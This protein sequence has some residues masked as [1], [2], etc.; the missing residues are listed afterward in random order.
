ME[1]LRIAFDI[2]ALDR[3]GAE[4]QTLEVA[5]GLSQAGHDV[6][7][8]VNKRADNFAEY[9]DQ[10]GIVELG[11]SSRWDA[12]VVADIRRALRAYDA[13]VCVCVLFNATLWGRLAAAWV[14]CPVVVAEHSTKA[15]TPIPE[16]SANVLLG[17]ATRA[18]IACADSQVG[19]LVRGGH[20]R[21]KIRVVRNG[22]NVGRF[23]PDREEAARL[24]ARLGIPP[25]GV[26]V[27]LAAAHRREKRQDRFVSLVERLHGRGVPVWGLIAGGGPLIHQTTA[28]VQVSPASS[29]LRVTG[30][31]E[32]MPAAYSAADVVVLVSDDIETF[33]LSFLEAQACEV[34]VVGMD[35][36]GVRETLVEG[37]TGFVV[38]QGDIEGMAEV[39]AALAADSDRRHRMG[40]AGREFVRERLSIEAMVSGYESV[41]TEVA[42]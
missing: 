29:R 16:R 1:T 35:T 15:V 5:A 24:R 32:D 19:A 20:Q 3:G 27:M 23:A 21:R 40:R 6:L 42:G 37:R 30:P 17:G 8:I 39:V 13:D 9:F 34:P 25:D 4:R 33:P 11:R 10:V 12:R 36:G 41:L 7:L 22:V 28:L 38:A 31:L 26:L 2:A 18:V 14:G